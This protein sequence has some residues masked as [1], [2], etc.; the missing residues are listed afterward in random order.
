MDNSRESGVTS[1]RALK[2]FYSQSALTE[3]FKVLSDDELDRAESN[4]MVDDIGDV[5]VKILD[6]IR[7]EREYRHDKDILEVSNMRSR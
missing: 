4:I 3:L 5:E 1:K 2:F 7:Q 6:V